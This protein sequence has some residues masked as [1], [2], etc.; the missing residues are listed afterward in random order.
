MS[1]NLLSVPVKARR[2]KN[3]GDLD[4]V[5]ES[6]D[7]IVRVCPPRNF[8]FRLHWT[9]CVFENSCDQQVETALRFWPELGLLPLYDQAFYQEARKQSTSASSTSGTSD[10]SEDEVSLW[11][12]IQS[13]VRSWFAVP[14]VGESSSDPISN[15]R[16]DEL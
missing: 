14:A 15:P 3:F 13:W 8:F 7:F 10:D 12:D 2:P 6:E 16:E 4:E 5:I 9:D 11:A 1:G